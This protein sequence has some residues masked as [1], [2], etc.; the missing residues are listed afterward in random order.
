MLKPSTKSS[1]LSGR[2]EKDESIKEKCKYA[3]LP[4]TI[5]L[6]RSLLVFLQELLKHMSIRGL[7]PLVV[8]LLC[9]NNVEPKLLVKLYRTLVIHLL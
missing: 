1:S 6:H 2:P 8:L 3:Y 4:N 5:A 9:L 7:Y